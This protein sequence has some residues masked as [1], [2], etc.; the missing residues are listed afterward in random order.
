MSVMCGMSA[1]FSALFGTP[2]AAA[3]FSVEVV[4]V[5]IMHYSAL[6]PCVT[7][8]LT[9]HLIARLFRVPPEVFP[10]TGI[11]ELTALGFLALRGC[12]IT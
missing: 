5:G 9:G 11:S 12:P 2:L 1:G 4:N 10:V 6:V 7:A 3:F 8:A